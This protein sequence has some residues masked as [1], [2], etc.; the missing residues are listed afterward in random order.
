MTKEAIVLK[1][2]LSILIAFAS[3]M[4]GVFSELLVVLLAVM[5]FDYVSGILRGFLTHSL[6]STIGMKGIM[7]KIGM[8]LVVFLSA[9]IEYVFVALELETSNVLVAVVICFFIVNEGISCLENTA[10]LGVPIPAFIYEA[11]EKL[12]EIGGKEQ[13]VPVRKRKEKAKEPKM[14]E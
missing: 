4:L 13:K 8:L 12:R 9:C 11:L 10:Q 5:M 14:K 6:N 1:A 3:Y 2:P 7:K